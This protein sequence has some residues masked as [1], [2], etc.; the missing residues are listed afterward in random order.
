M[1]SRPIIG[2][3]RNGVKSLSG[4]KSSASQG[5]GLVELWHGA[6]QIVWHHPGVCCAGG[7]IALVAARSFTVDGLLLWEAP[8]A[9]ANN[10][11][12]HWA[13]EF[14]R[15]LD[16]SKLEEAL[17]Q[18]MRDMPPQ[19]LEGAKRSPFYQ[20]MVEA[21]KSYRA[22]AQALSW[23][24]K[25]LQEKQLGTLLVPVEVAYG[26]QT[27][28][29]MRRSAD[30]LVASLPNAQQKALPGSNHAWEAEAMAKELAAFATRLES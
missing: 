16:E 4:F 15:R 19:W 12:P 11:I 23:V 18:Y 3:E 21:T 14:E 1:L 25:A 13:E 20:S 8:I 30:L 7:A 22:D 2:V 6:G 10:D 9:A 5:P 28:P 26:T 17:A 27:F 24:V 29:V